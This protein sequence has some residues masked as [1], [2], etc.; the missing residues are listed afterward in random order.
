GPVLVVHL[1]CVFGRHC[2]AARRSAGGQPQQGERSDRPKHAVVTLHGSLLSAIETTGPI[3][4]AEETRASL[5]PVEGNLSASFTTAS[6]M[7][8]AS[9]ADASSRAD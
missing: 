1:R 5:T 9:F 7:A 6:T 8:V 4:P 2:V 3:E